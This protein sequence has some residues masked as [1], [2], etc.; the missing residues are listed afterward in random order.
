MYSYIEEACVAMQMVETRTQRF[1]SSLMFACKRSFST[2]QRACSVFR[3]DCSCS[4]SLCVQ[5][6]PGVSIQN[7]P[8]K[9]SVRQ[10]AHLL[11]SAHLDRVNLDGASRVLPREL[12]AGAGLSARARRRRAVKFAAVSAAERRARRG[13]LPGVARH[14]L[15]AVH[16]PRFSRRP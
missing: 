2:S 13:G 4:N 7:T 15:L 6:S 14:P 8:S 3:R 10:S 1:S 5:C 9:S 16:T 11:A 12:I